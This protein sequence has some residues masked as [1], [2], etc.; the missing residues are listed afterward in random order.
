MQER[1]AGDR[2]GIQAEEASSASGISSRPTTA[3]TIPAARCRA[4]HSHRDYA[5]NHSRIVYAWGPGGR[6]VIYTGGTTPGQYAQDLT[7]L[8]TAP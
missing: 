2:I 4:T 1:A 3:S 5:V 6:S 7:R 8:A